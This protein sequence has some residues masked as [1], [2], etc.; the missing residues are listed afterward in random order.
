MGLLG[1]LEIR[2][3]GAPLTELTSAKA[4]ALLCYLTVT[5]RAHFRTSLAGLQWGDVPEASARGN[6][7]SELSK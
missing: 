7:R 2:L 3:D 1:K 5:G 6:L 4:Q